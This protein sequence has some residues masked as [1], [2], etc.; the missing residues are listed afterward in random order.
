P[1]RSTPPRPCDRSALPAGR[2]ARDRRHRQPLLPRRRRRRARGRPR[3]RAR[4]PPDAATSDSSPMSVRRP[5]SLLRELGHGVHDLPGLDTS[6][7]RLFAV[8]LD[9]HETRLAIDRAA[10]TLLLVVAGS[11]TVAWCVTRVPTELGEGDTAVTNPPAVEVLRAGV[12]GV[13]F[14]A[15]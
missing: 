15:L 12:D 9:P 1:P 7:F 3:R 4:S 11:L 10:E 13:T 6:Y 14:L 2:V 8:R 5:Y